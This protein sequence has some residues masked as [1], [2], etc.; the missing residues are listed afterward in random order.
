M[1]LHPALLL[2]LAAALVLTG[3]AGAAPPPPAPTTCSSFSKGFQSWISFHVQNTDCAAAHHLAG[4]WSSSCARSSRNSEVLHCD[5]TVLVNHRP[6]TFNCANRK[7]TH[8][9]SHYVVECGGVHH[10]RVNFTYYPHGF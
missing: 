4:T 9:P 7:A 8:S 3:S 1:R 6:V 10:H 5:L 2:A